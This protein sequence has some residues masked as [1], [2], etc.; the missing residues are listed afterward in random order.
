VDLKS[1]AIPSSKLFLVL[2]RLYESISSSGRAFQRNSFLPF[3]SVV[4]PWPVGVSFSILSGSSSFMNS[5]RLRFLRFLDIL[6]I[7]TYFL[8]I[9]KF[10][11]IKNVFERV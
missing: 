4:I 8:R 11:T 10:N 3:L 1:I 6:Y 7:L 2:I 5:F 9:S